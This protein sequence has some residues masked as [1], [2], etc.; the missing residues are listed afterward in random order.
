VPETLAPFLI[1]SLRVPRALAA[2]LCVLLC[3]ATSAVARAV[4]HATS[5]FTVVVVVV[6]GFGW[7]A[8][9][10]QAVCCDED[11]VPHTYLD[12][13][14]RRVKTQGGLCIQ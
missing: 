11:P 14:L 3:A 1:A 13:F 8:S 2:T 9:L 5:T 6:N 12:G 4:T 10:A 7:H